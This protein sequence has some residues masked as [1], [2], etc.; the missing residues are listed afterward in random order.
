MNSLECG[1]CG[2]SVADDAPSGVCPTCL[3]RT[4]IEHGSSHALA[5]FL[6]KLRYFGDYELLEE[7][8]RGG[9]GVVY[10]ARQVSLDR[11]VALKMMRPG[12]LSTE[13]E[14]RRFLSEARTAASLRHPHIVAIH[15]V[16]EFDGLHYFSMDFV[17][18][19][20]LAAIAREGPLAPDEAVRH[21]QILA[22][23]VQFAHTKGILH[24]DLKP[25]N[26]LVD[27]AGRP[28]I[29]DF[30]VARRIESDETITAS[31]AVI[32]T[33][34]YMA[35]EQASGEGRRITAASDVY[36]LGAILYELLTGRPPFR[37]DSQ[38]EIVRMVL[39]TEPQR[40]RSINPAVDGQI[41]AICLRCLAKDPARRFQSAGEL[42]NDLKRY[43]AGEPVH[44]RVRR[45]PWL[46][47][48]AGVCVVAFL[49]ASITWLKTGLKTEI[50]TEPAKHVLVTP[51]A[52]LPVEKPMAA[53]IAKSV[54]K[55]VPSRKLVV[56]VRP[57]P[58][59]EAISASVSPEN[60]LGYS[61]V[62]SFRYLLKEP[63]KEPVEEAASP[64]GIEIDFGDKTGADARHCNIVV[65]PSTGRVQLQFNPSG[66][67]GLR[68]AGQLGTLNRIENSICSVDLSDVTL[69]RQANALELRLGMTFKISFDGAR[70]IRS[71]LWTKQ[72]GSRSETTLSGQW[73]VGPN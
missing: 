5:P 73:T 70:A 69:V 14:I 34:A 2:K 18:G 71:W 23:T 63:V 7:I 46:S 11:T 45:S 35:P 10:R 19:P 12:L 26:V 21:V 61:Q 8:A 72:G 36:S 29:T 58:P 59:P 50:K 9:M 49:V 43:L 28:S 25:S 41:E 55:P 31:G 56:A 16:G 3:L 13:P 44:S 64:A 57:I 42:A 40:P 54:S 60:G 32:G 62:F 1:T 48:A 37:A 66:G 27:G 65:D 22:D 47:A 52:V 68:V 6:P 39:D 38:L 67:P 4:A 30:G 51:A 53:T 24:R 17:E 33:P 20:N 15:E